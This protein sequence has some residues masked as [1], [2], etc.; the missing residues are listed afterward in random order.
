MKELLLELREQHQWIL[1]LLA[2]P[3]QV[4]D[5]IHFVEKI[6]HPLE[7]EFLFPQIQD[8]AFLAKGGPR[9]TYF[10]GLILELNIYDSL[11]RPL[12]KLQNEVNF[13]PRPYPS[14]A[15]LT[16]Q[17]PLSM[18]FQEH[19]LGSEIAQALLYVVEREELKTLFFQ[20]LYESYSRLLKM[21]I[22][23]EDNCLFVMC[24]RAS[25]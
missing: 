19:V 21:H 25:F 9:C 10:R 2:Q 14:L 6:H 4:R 13:Q 17:S 23:K 7:E 1:K 18:P 5:L 3:E 16:P 8:Q 15:G 12:Q 22:D 20:D 11:R 24:E